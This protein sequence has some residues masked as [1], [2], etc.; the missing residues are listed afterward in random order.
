MPCRSLI[1]ELE[2]RRLLSLS[3]SVQYANG[4]YVL[5]GSHDYGL[6]GLTGATS[7]FHLRITFK[8]LDHDNAYLD[9]NTVLGS[10]DET[11]TIT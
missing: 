5:N 3:A 1:E 11:L 10:V 2:T 9:Q 7:T 4:E 8:L 6:V